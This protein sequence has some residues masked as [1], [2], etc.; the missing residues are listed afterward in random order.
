MHLIMSMMKTIIQARLLV[1]LKLSMHSKTSGTSRSPMIWTLR[2]SLK[3][4]LPFILG[5]LFIIDAVKF[6]FMNRQYEYMTTK[7]II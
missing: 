7:S 2:T 5:F 4:V 6:E 1:V 3:T